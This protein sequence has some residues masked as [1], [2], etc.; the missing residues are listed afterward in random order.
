VTATTF[1]FSGSPEAT[2]YTTRNIMEG[3]HSILLVVHDSNGDWQ[4][5]PGTVVETEDGV[6]VH[7][8]H[9]VEEHSEVH[10]LRDLPAGWAAERISESHPWERYVW[11]D[12]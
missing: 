3:R 6:A 7:L 9:I 2:C 4:F 1:P 8:F 11:A 12:S 10:E 5:L